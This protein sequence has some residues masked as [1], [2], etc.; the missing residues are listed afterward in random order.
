MPIFIPIVIGVAV[1]SSAVSVSQNLRIRNL[2][3][4][5]NEAY[6]HTQAVHAD[7]QE[8]IRTF[9]WKAQEYGYAKAL[10]AQD[11]QQAVDF[12]AK[13]RLKHREFQIGAATPEIQA[14]LDHIE[15][16]TQTFQT[17][18]RAASGPAAAA[19]AA[20]PG[21]YAA[22]GLFSVA[23]TGTQIPSLSGAAAHAAKMAA[24]GRDLGIGGSGMAAGSTALSSI[25]LGLNIISLPISLG[26][27]AW[28]VKKSLE[29]KN[30]VEEEI[31]K[32]AATETDIVRQS[33]LIGAITR[34]MADNR[35]S[36]AAAQTALLQ[37]LKQSD[38][39][40]IEQTH[41]VY[42]LADLLSQAIDAEVITPAQA[43][44]LGIRIDAPARPAP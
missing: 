41:G 1:V 31:K 32:L 40:D 43:R 9:N 16:Q 30:Q 13:A 12:L 37:Q 4:L 35:D 15:F 23:T 17:V 22:V 8:Q 33:A 10:A 24:I 6:A 28:S 25:T 44:E 2:K 21:I 27:A 38:P 26:A 14:R 39:E 18:L 3:K 20:A 5:Y 34:R 42:R 36:I 29:V 19:G 11:L 7:L